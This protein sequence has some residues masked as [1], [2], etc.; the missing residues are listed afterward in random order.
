M[1]RILFVDDES[2]VLDGIRRMLH[3]QR[4]VWEMVFV[5]SGEAALAE[6]EKSPFDV[7]VSDMRMPQMDGATLLAQVQERHPKVVR[8]VL[9]GHTE[10]EAALRAVPVAHQFLSK[11]CNPE[12]LIEVI[13]RASGLQELLSNPSLRQT[14][15]RIRQLPAFPRT[16][17]ALNAALM[18]PAVGVKDVAAIVEQDVGLCAKLLQLVNSAFFGLSRRVTNIETAVSLLGTNMIKNVVMSLEVFR[19]A[20]KSNQVFSSEL[21]QQHSFCTGSLAKALVKDARQAED[22]FMAGVL[23]DVG[24]LVLLTGIPDTFGKIASCA[25]E[26]KMQRFEIENEELQV[27]HAGVGAYLLGIW[28]LPYSIV[29]AVAYHHEPNV[30]QAVHIPV[31]AAVHVADRIVQETGLGD[32]NRDL[33]L[34]A[35]NQGCLDVLGGAENLP[36]WRN[37]AQRQCGA[38][39]KEK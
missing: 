4:A 31:L 15:G 39:G 25:A 37:L 12:Q 10:L 19:D 26:V 32:Q 27:T 13:R 29:E 18:N 1:K 21:L 3:K 20:P 6:L 24:E 14:I 17:R 36:A 11:P 34:A 2:R 30:V 23:H 5:G 35:I 38:V 22:A 16:Y 28:G 7:V 33:P 8:I 9:S